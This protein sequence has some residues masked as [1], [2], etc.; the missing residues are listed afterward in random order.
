MARPT[1]YTD[2][3]ADEICAR[4]AD[5]QS[6]RAICEGEDYPDR[7]TVFRWL[8]DPANDRFRNQYALARE[9]QAD[10]FADDIADIADD[11]KLEPNDKRVRIDARKWLAGKLRP[12][13]YGD[14]VAVTGGGAGDPPI[15]HS[16]AFDLTKASDK[17]LDVLERFIRRASDA[18]GD[19]GGAGEAEG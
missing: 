18:G 4:I 17:E 15:R 19:Q 11:E 13:V 16:H 1:S 10:S 6:L 9:S 12:K 5:G 7:S 8:S 3:I 2:E 14:K